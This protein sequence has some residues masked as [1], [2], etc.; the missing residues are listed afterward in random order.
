M[1]NA[2][3]Y[4]GRHRGTDNGQEVKMKEMQVNHRP[5]LMIRTLVHLNMPKDKD[6]S[7]HDSTAS[8]RR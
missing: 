2:L 7:T 5:E 1:T 6:L 4:P 3:C 8:E